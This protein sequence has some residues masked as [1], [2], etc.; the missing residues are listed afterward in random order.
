MERDDI[1]LSVEALDYP[2]YVAAVISHSPE[3]PT[4]R[5]LL[6]ADAVIGGPALNEN[7]MSAPHN[8]FNTV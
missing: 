5:R 6:A 1:D 8:L 3:N 7:Y 2:D 4:W